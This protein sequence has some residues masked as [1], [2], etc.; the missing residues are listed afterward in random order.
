MKAQTMPDGL[1]F[2]SSVRALGRPR[3]AND[4]RT[5]RR[6]ILT[7]SYRLARVKALG[8]AESE[9]AVP[10]SRLECCRLSVIQRRRFDGYPAI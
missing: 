3:G 4:A 2:E 9:K 5:A 1:P 6:P 8:Q 7:Y 10:P